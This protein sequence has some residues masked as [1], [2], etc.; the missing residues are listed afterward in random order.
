[1]DAKSPI[2]KPFPKQGLSDHVRAAPAPTEPR[3]VAPQETVVTVVHDAG[4]VV[5]YCGLSARCQQFSGKLPESGDTIPISGPHDPPQ[6]IAL[7]I[8]ALARPI[9]PVGQAVPSSGRDEA[10]AKSAARTGLTGS[11]RVSSAQGPGTSPPSR[12]AAAMA[13]PI[14]LLK[15]GE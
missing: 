4:R 13:S 3:P 2:V 12:I 9:L 7:P 15:R 14:A 1:M 5:G 11:P 8:L 6:S 10:R